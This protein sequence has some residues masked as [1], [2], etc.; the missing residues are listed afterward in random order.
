MDQLVDPGLIAW[1]EMG[2]RMVCWESPVSKVEAVQMQCSLIE[3]DG[4]DVNNDLKFIVGIG[5]GVAQSML[6]L[7]QQCS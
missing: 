6:A 2:L 7:I 3:M 5:N 1:T 4:I